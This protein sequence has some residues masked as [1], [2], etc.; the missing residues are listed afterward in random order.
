MREQKKSVKSQIKIATVM[1]LNEKSY[2]DITVTDI[3]NS[4]NIA[5]ASFYRNYMSIADVFD[6]I[7][8]DIFTE[9]VAEVIPVLKSNDENGWR[10]LLYSM[11][12]RFPKHHSVGLGTKA[13]N[14]NELLSR[15]SAKL[16]EIEKLSASQTI[17]EKYIGFGKMGLVVNIIKKWMIDGRKESPEEMVNF[18]MTFIT[19]F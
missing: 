12:Y 5:R 14:V 16:Q 10:E 8:D 2:M 19:K 17:R 6:D 3:V 18:V 13:E 15:M 11:F 7:V 9:I 4:A 1:L